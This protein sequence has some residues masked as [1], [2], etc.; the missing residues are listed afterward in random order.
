MKFDP[1]S[2]KKAAKEDFDSAWTSG[3]DLIKKT[4]LNQQYPHTSFH[5]GKAHPVY[6]TIAKL[7]EAYLRMGFDEMMNPLIVDEKEVYKQ[8]GHEALAVLDRC[9]YLAGLPRPNVGISDQRIAKIKEM[10]GGIDDEGIETIRKVLHSYKKGEVEG[11]DLV[12]EIALKLNVSDALVVEMIDKVF[13]EFK[14]LTPQATTKTLRSHM[15][16]GWFISLSGILERSRPP[17]HLFSIDRSF[18]REQQED[19][20]RLMTYYSA[21]CVIMDEDVTVDHGKAVAQGL[22]AQFG[23][24]KFMFRPDEKRSKYYVP[25]TQIEVF[26]YHPKLVGSNTKYSDGWI[27]I[28]TFGIYSPTALAEYNIPCPVMNLGLGVERLAMI[29]HD[30][31]DLRGMTYPQLPQYAEWELKD[32]ELARMIFVDKLPET[33]EGQEILE[34][35]VMQCDMHGS[36]PSPCEFVAWEGILKGKKVKVSVIEPEEDTKLCGPAAYNEV[37]VHE[38]DVLGL[39]NNKK[40]KKAF[41]NH[42]AR[43]GVRFIEA[44]AAQAAKEIEEAVE[45]GEKECETRVRIVKVPSEINIKLDPLAQRY[46]TGKKQKIDI[47][48]PVFTTVRAEIE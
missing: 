39:P 21:S 48:G 11:D 32:N 9:Y 17:F 43:T 15:T 13:P 20:S 14:E 46:I 45:K 47:R 34:G 2:I 19:A 18:R 23:F 4:G 16:S 29:L 40:W 6:D 37:L 7:R 28:A 42:S 12:P 5:F 38:N 33:P 44:F 10:L 3:K 31:T 25:D 26:A 35:I 30:S 22:L 1:E 41:E 8:F 27:E 24:E 36:E